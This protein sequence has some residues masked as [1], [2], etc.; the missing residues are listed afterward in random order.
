[1]RCRSIWLVLAV[2]TVFVSVTLSALVK[3]L[4]IISPEKSC[5][6]VIDPFHCIY[7]ALGDSGCCL[8]FFG[9]LHMLYFCEV[10]Y[11]KNPITGRLHER[12]PTY[13]EWA[14]DVCTPITHEC[15]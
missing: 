3:P 15:P 9:G 5:Q 10:E 8:H 14:L 11:W 4:I 6:D 12:N 1:M 13:C 2:V 7:L